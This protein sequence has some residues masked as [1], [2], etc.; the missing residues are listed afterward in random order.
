MS[1]QKEIV[2]HVENVSKVFAPNAMGKHALL[3]LGKA[4]TDSKI[5]ALNDISFKVFQGEI[6]GIVGNNG[7]GKS[8]LLKIISGIVKPSKGKITIHGEIASILEVGTGFHPD[9]SGYDNI[10][11]TGSLNGKSKDETK[12]SVADII[13]FSGLEQFINLPVKYYSSGMFMRLAFATATYMDAD[14]ILLDEV[15]SVGDI[16]FK[17]KCIKRIR[18]LIANG[19]TIVLVSHDLSIVKGIC[20]RCIILDKGTVSEDGNVND[21]MQGY[22]LKALQKEANVTH[23]ALNE[24]SYTGPA[25][26]NDTIKLCSMKV[27]N[28]N[29]S[30]DIYMTDGIRIDCTYEKPST[31]FGRVSL[32]IKSEQQLPFMALSPYRNTDATNITDDTEGGIYTA[33]TIIPS[34]LFNQGLFT[35]D[36]IFIDE[37]E[38][39]LLHL[40]NV[41]YFKIKLKLNDKDMSLYSGAFPGP[42][43]P[44]LPWQLTK[45]SSK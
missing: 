6:L 8:T 37:N 24:N 31:K 39:V 18:Q 36:F 11:L 34:N 21:I 16:E 17:T 38:K 45:D 9:L 12:K 30:G 1:L 7:A 4:T 32:N 29:G 13:A 20:T 44:V 43:M 33:T 28:D 5:T 14:I 10:L 35:I 22:M 3:N 15:F 27:Y 40:P 19:K 25:L 23:T 41:C 2:L 42:L 26:G